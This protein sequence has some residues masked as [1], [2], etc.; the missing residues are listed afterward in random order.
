M[1]NVCRKPGEWQTY[2]ILW[3]VPHYKSDGSVER[4]AYVTVLQN[5]VV[6]QNHFALLGET[7]F[8]HAPE[9]KKHADTGPIMLQYH[10]NPVR[11]RNIWVR[12]MKPIVPKP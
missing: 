3:E 8:E 6:V 9:Y 4:P 10:L 12:P 11:F 7:A 5:G 1:V 2:D